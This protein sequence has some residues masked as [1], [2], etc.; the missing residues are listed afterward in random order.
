MKVASATRKLMRNP[1][2]SNSMTLFGE[3]RTG[4]EPGSPDQEKRLGSHVLMLERIYT[5][6][7][8]APLLPSLEENGEGANWERYWRKSAAA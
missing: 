1:T 5:D 6:P 3:F 4:A 7:L 2:F 8:Y